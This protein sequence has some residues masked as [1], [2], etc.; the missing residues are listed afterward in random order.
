M[1]LQDNPSYLSYCVKKGKVYYKE[2]G[3]VGYRYYDS[4]DMQVLFPFGHGLSY[5]TFEYSNLQLDKEQMKD[6]EMLHIS[7]DV[8]NTGKTAGKEVVQIYVSP[9]E[10]DVIRP[11]KELKGFEKVELAPGSGR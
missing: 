6:L 2:E 3:F 9:T 4:K 7:V 1:K 11:I 10:C 5:T 8:K